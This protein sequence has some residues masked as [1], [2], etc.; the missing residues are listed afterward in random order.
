[1]GSEELISSVKKLIVLCVKLKHTVNHFTN[2][3]KDE[4]KNKDN[5]PVT[6]G[7]L[8]VVY[9]RQCFTQDDFVPVDMSVLMK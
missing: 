9:M 5:Y 3:K 8:D 1:M 2:K 7:S 6:P 4:E